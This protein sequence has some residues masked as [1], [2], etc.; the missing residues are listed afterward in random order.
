MMNN[1]MKVDEGGES[2]QFVP[3][4]PPASLLHE[5]VAEGEREDEVETCEVNFVPLEDDYGVCSEYSD[6]EP[7]PVVVNEKV[8]VEDEGDVPEEV[9]EIDDE[10][11]EGDDEVDIEFERKMADKRTVQRVYQGVGEEEDEAD[12][13]LDEFMRETRMKSARFW[14]GQVKKYESKIDELKRELVFVKG[15]FRA[16]KRM[17][18]RQKE[19]LDRI[20]VVNTQ[21]QDE[22]WT[23][24]ERVTTLVEDN[25]RREMVF[26]AGQ[27]KKRQRV[28]ELKREVEEEK[29]RRRNVEE[30][31]EVTRKRL[32]TFTRRSVPRKSNRVVRRVDS[33]EDGEE[34]SSI[35]VEQGS[36]SDEEEKRLVKLINI[37]NNED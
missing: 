20:I 32:W 13:G 35:S 19:D 34:S 3:S 22:N 14:V 7:V 18:D 4:T 17:V 12:D 23:L 8:E 11:D 6:V 36:S 30:E 31:L 21:L 15:G 5:G 9:I 16:A 10:S 24:H 1:A 37:M 29:R 25:A 26:A 27:R 28:Q 33:Y 2:W